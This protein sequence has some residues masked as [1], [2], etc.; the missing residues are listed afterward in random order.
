MARAEAA[1][2]VYQ[3]F[4]PSI[5]DAGRGSRS[6]LVKR[7]AKANAKTSAM[8]IS[9]CR[10][11]KSGSSRFFLARLSLGISGQHIEKC[12]AEVTGAKVPRGPGHDTRGAPDMILP[13]LKSGK[14]CG[15]YEGATSLTKPL[16]EIWPLSAYCGG[17]FWAF[18]SV[19]GLVTTPWSAASFMLSFG[20]FSA[21]WHRSA[22]PMTS[23]PRSNRS[24]I[25]GAARF[26]SLFLSSPNAT[27]RGELSGL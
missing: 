12:P 27:G 26:L 10:T 14:R 11:L 2:M 15:P 23:M 9:H 1:S 16:A 13:A 20:H 4:K 6:P 22:E 25:L 18:F 19:A 24:S 21:V 7:I 5:G 8:R 17:V 3:C